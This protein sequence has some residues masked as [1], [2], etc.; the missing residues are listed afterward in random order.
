MGRWW[1]CRGLQHSQAPAEWSEAHSPEGSKI[2]CRW[3]IPTRTIPLP[4]IQQHRGN[5][6]L[7]R[8]KWK[9]FKG[10]SSNFIISI[11]KWLCHVWGFFFVNEEK[12]SNLRIKQ[13]KKFPLLFIKRNEKGRENKICV[14]HEKTQFKNICTNVNDDLHYLFLYLSKYTDI[15]VATKIINCLSFTSM[16]SSC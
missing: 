6:S 7:M 9:H 3:E 14:P 2:D 1:F 4:K 5:H 13:I 10:R 8:F 11:D 15:N 12:R 16:M